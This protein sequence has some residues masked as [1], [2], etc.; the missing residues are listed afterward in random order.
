MTHDDVID[1]LPGYVLGAL[2]EEERRLVE[3]ALA[4][5]PNARARLTEYEASAA[6][7][8][9]LAP[10][11]SAPEHL[12]ADLRAR[13]ASRQEATRPHI[14]AQSTSPWVLIAA[15]AALVVILVGA[16]AVLWL[17]ND[18]DE[19]PTE[20]GGRTLY[21]ELAELEGAQRYTV[22]PGEVDPGVSGELVVSPEGDRAVIRVEE[23]PALTDEN[24]FQ[25][26][27]VDSEGERS[28][29]GLFRQARADATYIEIPLAAPL[30]AYRGF[31]VSLE[32]AGGSPYPD[33]PTGPRVFSVPIDA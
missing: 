3:Q 30:N 33:R 13:L 28:S 4:S 23:L 32:P 27:L 22:M 17:L 18:D 15:A 1:L 20:D 16:V 12:Q 14:T 11:R 5:D 10:L 24:I 26:W 31:G 7:L 25:L 8:V 19:P 2:D 6:S 9:A 29:G 21:A